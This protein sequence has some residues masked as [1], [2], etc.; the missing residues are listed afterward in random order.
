MRP[1]LK[2]LAVLI[3]IILVASS[4]YVIIFSEPRC[5]AK[6]DVDRYAEEP[7]II[8]D[9]GNETDNGNG[10]ENGN[11]EKYPWDS[12]HFVF[13]E[14]ATGKDCHPCLKIGKILH[15]LYESGKYPLYYI[16]LIG[17]QKNTAEYLEKHYNYFAY[18]SVYIDGAYRTLFGGAT[19]KSTMEKNIRE[20][21]SRDFSSVYINVTAE[22]DQNNSEIKIEGKIKNDGNSNYKGFLRIYLT[23][24]ITTDW[25]DA[26]KK[27]YHF[28]SHSYITDSHT[29]FQS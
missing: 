26:S 27:P 18:P 23:E 17:D 21:L 16:S 29:I 15:E 3:V 13:I 28:G 1:I 24:I 2:N 20:A 14:E 25:L 12:T 4:A 11:K 5:G 9:D 7:E 6:P 19:E 10:N 22:W 8:D